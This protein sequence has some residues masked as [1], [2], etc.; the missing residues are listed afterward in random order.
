M[1]IKKERAAFE[2]A[3]NDA[4]FFPRELDFTRT[5]S[6]S[7]RDEYANSHLQSNWNG[8]LARGAMEKGKVGV[9]GVQAPE[10]AHQLWTRWSDRVLILATPEE[11]DKEIKTCER[12]AKLELE[13]FGKPGW[14]AG[15]VSK[16]KEGIATYDER[17]AELDDLAAEAAVLNEE[18]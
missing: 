5:K 8:W 4:R 12:Q 17:L 14:W 6:P 18:K 9:A 3:M 2:K 13:Q 11:M 16:L 1:D 15:K 10:G 7:G